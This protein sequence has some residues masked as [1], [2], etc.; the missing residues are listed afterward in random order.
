MRVISGS[1]YLR[2]AKKYSGNIS[3]IARDLKT[4]DEV[5]SVIQKKYSD[6]FEQPEGYGLRGISFGNG[7]VFVN[8]IGSDSLGT[9]TTLFHEMGH[10]AARLNLGKELKEHIGDWNNRFAFTW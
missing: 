8:D 5:A 10:E 2:L 9:A 7:T 4:T 6:I 3:R 1:E